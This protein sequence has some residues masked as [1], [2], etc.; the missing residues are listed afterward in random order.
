MCCKH[1]D[2]M[3]IHVLFFLFLF[4]KETIAGISFFN[5]SVVGEWGTLEACHK[6]GRTDTIS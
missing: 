1:T 2:S 5:R 6:T 3:G 4:Y